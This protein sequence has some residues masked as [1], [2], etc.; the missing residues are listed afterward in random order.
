MRLNIGVD[1]AAFQASLK[2]AETLVDASM[3]RMQTRINAIHGPNFGGGGV[4]TN[5]TRGGN[6]LVNA[7]SGMGALS[8]GLGIGAAVTGMAM[9]EQGFSR[10]IRKAKEFQTATLAIAATLGSIGSWQGAGNRPL[11][12]SQQAQRNMWEAEKYRQTILV[13]SA[14]NILT[15]DEQLQ[16]FQSGLA[17][18][19]RKGLKPDQIMKLTE[20]TAIVAK[21][22]G[23]R[24]EQIS[25]AS[26]L[27]MGGGVNVARST[28]GRALGIS[29]ADI[30]T[31]SGPQLERFLQS[32]MKGFD[33]M[34]SK[35]EGSIEGMVSTLEAKIDVL[36]ARAGAKFMKGIAPTLKQIGMLSEPTRD[37]FAKGAKGTEQFTKSLKSYQQQS[38]TMDTLVN[39][40]AKGFNG[41]FNG[42]KAV[43][44]SDSF[45]T[46]LDILVR[47]ASVS[48]QI[49]L[50][51]VFS[52]IASSVMAATAAMQRF[53]AVSGLA[54]RSGGIGGVGPMGTMPMDLARA[55]LMASNR[56]LLGVGATGAGGALGLAGYGSG[57]PILRDPT[58]AGLRAATAARYMRGNDLLMERGGAA[59]AVSALGYGAANDPSIAGRIGTRG[60]RAIARAANAA[61][62]MDYRSIQKALPGLAQ[63]EANLA[64]R[65]PWLRSTGD[66]AG[67]T[68]AEGRLRDI[69]SERQALIAQREAIPTRNLPWGGQVSRN[70][71]ATGA[72][73]MN[74][75]PMGVMGVM[76]GQMVKEAGWGATGTLLGSGIQGGALGYMLGGNRPAMGAGIGALGG[77]GSGVAQLG[78]TA[79]MV[80]L[81]KGTTL[82]QYAAMSA[83]G[84]MKW[85]A[86]GAMIGSMVA[87]G[88]G[89]AVGGGIGAVAGGILEP[90][91]S[92]MQKAEEQA[93]A[94]AA[95]LADMADRFPLGAK[96]ADLKSDLRAINKKIAPLQKDIEA[97]K[98]Q[99]PGSAEYMSAEWAKKQIAPLLKER[100][101]ITRKIGETTDQA[102]FKTTNDRRAERIAA[103]QG[104]IQLYSGS[105][106]QG[107]SARKKLLGLQKE[108]SMLNVEANIRSI[109]VA[110][111]D[112]EAAQKMRGP[113]R[114]AYS[115]QKEWDAAVKVWEKTPYAKELQRKYAQFQKNP[116]NK[117]IGYEQWTTNR[118]EN[119]KTRLQRAAAPGIKSQI[120]TK[121][122]LE[123]MDIGY[124]GQ[125]LKALS[126]GK[127]GLAEYISYKSEQTQ[128]ASQYDKGL[129]DPGFKKYLAAQLRERQRNIKEDYRA[130]AFDLES[131]QIDLQRLGV[132]RKRAA[133]DTP[134][135]IQQ[136]K[137]EAVNIDIASRQT[138]LDLTKLKATGLERIA[139]QDARLGINSQR[140]GLQAQSLL[141]ERQQIGI[142]MFRNEQ[143]RTRVGQ[144]YPLNL[145][146]GNLNLQTAQ[147]GQRAAAGAPAL[148][149]GG[150]GPVQGAAASIRNYVESEFAQKFDPA[151]YEAAY[152]DKL[153][154]EEEQLRINQKLADINTK[155]AQLGLDRIEEDYANTLTDLTMQMKGLLISKE[156]NALDRK[157]NVIDQ[158]Q[159]A[160]D[161]VE[162]QFARAQYGL[163]IEKLQSQQAGNAFAASGNALEQGRVS[164]DAAMQAKDDS[165]AYRLLTEKYGM[166]SRS[167][168]EARQTLGDVVGIPKA[169]LS[170]PGSLG[171]LIQ[172]GNTVGGP[173]IGIGPAGMTPQ[174]LQ[175]LQT[176][177]GAQANAAYNSGG[178]TTSNNSLPN[179]MG[180]GVTVNVGDIHGG[181]D[182]KEFGKVVLDKIKGT[183]ED[184]NVKQRLGIGGS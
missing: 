147:M 109:P 149:Y 28:I 40:A 106:S 163:D 25:N 119:E 159:N 171:G 44:E 36:S 94:S 32:K 14:K 142:N 34:Q 10:A 96:V 29:N 170:I 181:M 124:G 41:L 86:T 16:S 1:L 174:A 45:K 62:R 133:E 42:V 81:K 180:G 114:E 95:A 113:Q 80:D 66:S 122:D 8:T 58:R 115:T 160:V 35:F 101:G 60:Q 103:L 173:G 128:K 13:R 87:P 183:I 182:A 134:R 179:T 15:F 161:I 4:G 169:S 46:L 11:P 50:A 107:P 112:Y 18:G 117:G 120:G 2:S 23:L 91:I 184:Y 71:Q 162:Q 3:G 9:L 153:Q 132:S 21:T 123:R 111:N 158:R 156:T 167:V 92:S 84:A 68:A 146:E 59:G 85:G 164:E 104:Q 7:V 6:Q 121:I 31:R 82:G 141:D 155:R 118:T 176:M 22:L 37:Q 5:L 76:G 49:M 27:L 131:T 39:S 178:V 47:I 152:R 165:R 172:K 70:L 98:N 51:M 56:G 17:S 53:L 72:G 129:D 63:E 77:I 138:T 73:L 140:L 166:Q 61:G 130:K 175:A 151:E 137:L 65:I 139:L 99:A 100:S 52:K 135:K 102:Y 57:M 75:L 116:D 69:Q 78:K 110:Y 145:A 19:A 126:Q 54:G 33:Q 20:Q 74:R 83:G 55:T 136:L 150:M 144:D 108:L 157:A 64:A 177:P 105:M 48:K 148:F 12:Q 97:G 79:S 143:A 30:S 168:A 90:L 88:V 127:R 89:T 67:A 43:V 26:R 154:M 24:G 93:K 38:K 125:A